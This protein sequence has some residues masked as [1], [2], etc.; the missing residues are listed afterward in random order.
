MSESSLIKLNV[1]RTGVRFWNRNRAVPEPVCGTFR[2]ET[3]LINYASPQN[4]NR[5]QAH[6]K[7]ESNPYFHGNCKVCGKNGHKGENCRS[8]WICDLCGGKFHKSDTCHKNPDRKNVS[9][10]PNQKFI[11]KDFQKPQGN[12]VKGQ[13]S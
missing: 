9:R 7:A 2:S 13:E 1:V 12:G 6:G 11:R 10:F 8:L 4:S 3:T 5:W